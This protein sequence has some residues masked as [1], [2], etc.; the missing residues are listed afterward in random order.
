VPAIRGDISV[1]PIAARST[2][3]AGLAVREYQ[4]SQTDRG[5]RLDLSPPAASVTRRRWPLA[6]RP[7]GCGSLAAA[8]VTVALTASIGEQTPR[9]GRSSESSRFGREIGETGP[10]LRYS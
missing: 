8:E 9:Q 10:L 5:L 3:L 6:H 4:G 1:Q 2:L 7:F